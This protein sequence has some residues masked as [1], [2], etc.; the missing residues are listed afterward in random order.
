MRNF[1][2]PEHSRYVRRDDRLQ[3]LSEFRIRSGDSKMMK[4]PDEVDRRRDWFG[5]IHLELNDELCSSDTLSLGGF[6]IDL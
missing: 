4:S 5:D 3:R 1:H 2:G 6:V